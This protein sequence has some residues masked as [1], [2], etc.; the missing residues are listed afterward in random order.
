MCKPSHL[1]LVCFIKSLRAPLSFQWMFKIIPY[2]LCTNCFVHILFRPS[3]R[4]ESETL[5]VKVETR[6]VCQYIF[7]I[8]FYFY[9]SGISLARAVLSQDLCS[10]QTL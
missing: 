3:V 8:V 10:I 6:Y 7:Q 5:P 2:C 4:D 1:S 9:H